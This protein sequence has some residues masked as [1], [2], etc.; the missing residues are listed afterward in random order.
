MSELD[1]YRKQAIDN[2][3][4]AEKLPASAPPSP[5]GSGDTDNPPG[6]LNDD[7][8]AEVIKKKMDAEEQI[9]TAK[10]E[11]VERSLQTAQLDIIR[12]LL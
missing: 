7:T 6:I 10:V 8:V 5:G 9:D 1:D 12:D 11:L 2:L 3:M 4:E